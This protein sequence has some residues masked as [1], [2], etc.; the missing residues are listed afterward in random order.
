[1][2]WQ[3]DNEQREDATFAGA[4]NVTYRHQATRDAVRME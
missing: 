3:W 2:F 1:M 4:M